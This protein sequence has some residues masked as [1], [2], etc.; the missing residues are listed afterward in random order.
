MRGLIGEML[1]F[2]GRVVLGLAEEW[3]QRRKDR[4]RMKRDQAT[5][6]HPKDVAIQ[7]KAARCAGRES[8]PDCFP[9]E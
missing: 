3:W 9:P 4:A 2:G 8:S 1:A 7:S 6:M 5:G